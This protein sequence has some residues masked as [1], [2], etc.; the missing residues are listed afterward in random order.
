MFEGPELLALKRFQEWTDDCNQAAKVAAKKVR[1]PLDAIATIPSLDNDNWSAY[2]QIG[3]LITGLMAE[4]SQSRSFRSQNWTFRRSF[5]GILVELALRGHFVP[6]IVR[7]SAI[8]CAD[9]AFFTFGDHDALGINGASVST[10]WGDLISWID[11]AKR[12]NVLALQSRN[13]LSKNHRSSGP[14]RSRLL[15]GYGALASS[16]VLRISFWLAL[17]AALQENP[18]FHLLK[19]EFRRSIFGLPAL[20]ASLISKD[21]KEIFTEFKPKTVFLPFENQLWQRLVAFHRGRSLVVGAIHSAPRKWDLRFVA[22]DEDLGFAPNFLISNGNAS[23][24]LLKNLGVRSDRVLRGRALRY[25][26]FQHD[27]DRQAKTLANLPKV[28]LV[29]GFNRSEA[30]NLI[31]LCDRWCHERGLE[32]VLRPHPASAVWISKRFKTHTIDMDALETIAGKYP[33]FIADNMSSLALELY[34][35]GLR[36]VVYQENGKLNLS[37]MSMHERFRGYFGSVNDLE[38]VSQ[39]PLSFPEESILETSKVRETWMEIIEKVTD[40]KEL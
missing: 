17:K 29:T 26:D 30:K 37:P 38:R 5:L 40:A 3:D 35:A 6:Q 18:Y 4:P 10:F 32:L 20:E 11:E 2:P 39:Q 31:R 12:P 8:S 14:K 25:R 21:V 28:L 15:E 22:I 19:S 36:V 13:L 23:E 34:E 33:L 1:L 7:R 27:L 24:N 9:V 16:I